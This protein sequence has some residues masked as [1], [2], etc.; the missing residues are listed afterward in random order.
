M[1]YADMYLE[2]TEKA[3][4]GDKRFEHLLTQ[5]AIWNLLTF[6]EKSGDYTSYLGESVFEYKGV[7]DYE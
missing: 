6:I 3:L 1:K 4:R 2:H 7:E 5:D